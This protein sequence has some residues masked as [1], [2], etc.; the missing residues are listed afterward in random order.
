MSD[1]VKFIQNKCIKRV[2]SMA[3]LP[4]KLHEFLKSQFPLLL[5]IWDKIDQL[6][7]KK[8]A[9]KPK[10]EPSVAEPIAAP[11]SKS[12]ILEL[13]KIRAIDAFG[14]YAGSKTHVGISIGTSS[15]KLIELRKTGKIWQLLHFGVV[16]LPEDVIVNREVVNPVALI[17]NI[18]VL[19]NQIKLKNKNVCTSL[20]G[21]SLIIKRMT[22][23]TTNKKDLQDQVFWEAEQYLPF[24]VSE[25]VMD[26]HLLSQMSEKESD[27][28]F[29]AVKKSVL[30][31]YMNCISEAGLKPKIVDLDFFALQNLVEANYPMSPT[32]ATAV[33]DV[34]ASSMKIVIT[35]A[36]V[37]VFTKDTGI[38]G[39]NLTAEIQRSLGL[40]FADAESL[41]IS[42]ASSGVV[43]QEVGDLMQNM[44]DNLAVEIK[45]TIDFYH[46]SSSGAPVTS[47]LLTG[48]CASI[49]GF[50]KVVEDVVNLP[51]QL[52]NPFNVISYDPSV[53]TPEYLNT[54]APLAAI[55][56]GLALRAGAS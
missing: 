23:S 52:M 48:G 39:K 9:D 19:I 17:E 22:V 8:T 36:G 37:P 25:V 4:P 38:G 1:S 6:K 18:K 43:P 31:A 55:P 10:V 40:S 12:R 46:A 34:G 7:Q 44:A 28:I 11:K 29:V 27:V 50:S 13:I 30:E 14:V 5:S 24:D 16:N 56:I 15:I 41:K 53:F 3:K 51:A 33:V 49:P 35:S 47:V 21:T 32:E 45:K 26:F 54:I 20:S 42:G 2:E